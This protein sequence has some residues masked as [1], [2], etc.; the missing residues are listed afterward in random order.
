MPAHPCLRHDALFMRSRIPALIRKKRY[1]LQ[2][3]GPSQ[4]FD[5]ENELD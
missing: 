1:R 5:A 2:Q 4:L 3:F